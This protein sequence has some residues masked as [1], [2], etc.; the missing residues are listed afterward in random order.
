MNGTL[1]AI[2]AYMV[3]IGWNGNGQRAVDRF[4]EDFSGFIPV[5][6]AIIGLTLLSKTRLSPIVTPFLT[7][8]I[9]TTIVRNYNTIETDVKQTFNTLGT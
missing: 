5:V 4:S 7:L 2:A 6:G 1:L 3:A 9:I 8:A